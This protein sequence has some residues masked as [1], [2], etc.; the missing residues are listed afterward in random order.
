[1]AGSEAGTG[2]RIA[3]DVLGGDR[4]PE[5]ILE[6]ARCAVERGLV[7]A[8]R[9][10]LVGPEELVRP[11]AE[12]HG[13]AVMAAQEAIGMGERPAVAVRD[14]QRSTI[15]VGA[16]AIAS[17]EVGALVSAGNTGAV[18][19]ASLLYIG[20]VRGVRRPG[21][22]A[23]FPSREGAVTLI[24]AGANLECR[25][26]D[27]VAF[28]RMAAEF[29]RGVDGIE[30]PR[31]AILNVGEEDSRGTDVVRTARA[32]L[33]NSDL[34]FVGNLE[35]HDLFSGRADVVVCEGFVGN[36]ALKVSEGLGQ[37]ITG[38]L[39]DEIQRH[40]GEADFSRCVEIVRTLQERTDYAAYG[41]A[42]LLGVD[43]LVLICHGRSDRRAIGN[44]L[45]VAR[46]YLD[47]GVQRRI[48]AEMSGGDGMAGSE[49]R[50]A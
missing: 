16:R 22:A 29:R 49:R 44:A 3:L 40:E 24:D 26:E 1:M 20:R 35:G 23:T 30:D 17:G 10:V 2:A 27:L 5:E 32:M 45:G 19:A 36:V 12:A 46:R 43:G 11:Q 4:A 33:S 50:D 42:P 38:I 28:A 31:V 39:R 14:K 9:I 48:I 41:G 8:D 6:G 7:D 37:F 18:V 13:F 21:I 25:A 15:V 34:R 47:A